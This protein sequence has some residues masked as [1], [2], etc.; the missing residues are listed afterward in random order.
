MGT[1]WIL[2]GVWTDADNRKR[3]FWARAVDQRA[4][5]LTGTRASLEWSIIG[6][7]GVTSSDEAES[8]AASP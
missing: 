4:L 1:A 3:L 6:F 2:A 5:I 7:G 8:M